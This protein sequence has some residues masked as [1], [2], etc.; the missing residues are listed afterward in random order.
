MPNASAA[1]GGD[2]VHQRMTVSRSGFVAVFVLVL[3]G[4]LCAA[5]FIRCLNSIGGE[6]PFRQAVFAPLV[7]VARILIQYRA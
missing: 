5:T 6:M 4:L 7:P 3:R 1:S 2:F